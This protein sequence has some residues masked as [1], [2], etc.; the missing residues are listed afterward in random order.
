M[1][2]PMT[3]VADLASRATHLSPVL[4]RYFERSWS[5]GIGHRLYDTA[6]RPYLDFANGI[7]VTAL[8]HV[9]PRVTA[10][11][12]AQVDRLV[13]PINAIGF[14]EPISRLADALAATF[15]DPL[16]SVMFMN[17]GSEAI[18]AAL[19]LARRVTGRPGII[20]FRGGFH[21]RTF[22]AMSVTS[23]AI[24]YRVGHEP[25]L[26]GV[27][28]TTFPAVYRTFGGDEEAAVAQ[29]MADLRTVTETEIP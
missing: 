6:G 28:L 26:P 7:A 16:D 20:A 13:G 2:E 12:H 8:G 15:P 21:G 27:H 4:G 23:T 29:R 18:D 3:S 9:H 14:T 11:I 10:A 17:S 24:N 25:L 19:K 22:G 5:H 1:D